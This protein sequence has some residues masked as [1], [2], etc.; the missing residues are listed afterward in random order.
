MPEPLDATLRR[1]KEERDEADRR[2]NDALTALDRAVRPPPELPAA[3][4]AYDEHQ[5]TPLNEA[6]NIIPEPPAGG[7]L[8]GRL[9][10]LIWRTVGPFLQRQLTF[11]SR[12]VDH[13]NRNVAAHREARHSVDA[14]V[15]AMREQLAHQ[16]DNHSR[17]LFFLQQI[18]P[19][20][21][22]KD[23]DSAGGALVLNASLSALA[24]SMAKRW[25]SMIAREQR[26]Q[27]R[28]AALSA[29]HEDLRAA[30]GVAQQAALTTKR[31][32]ERIAAGATAPVAAPAAGEPSVSGEVFSSRLDAYKYVAFEDQFRGSRDAIRSRLESYLPFFEGRSNV[33]DV[34]CGRGE[35]LDLLQSRGIAAQGIEDRKSTR[36]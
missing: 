8:A 9:T 3:P 22:T 34:G 10:G 11:N 2:Y 13:L 5:I 15:A 31:E 28:T 17:L 12:L 16:A 14:L 1:L 24:E 35:F 26:Y 29:A 25:E 32:L 18:T 7:G 36:L 4:A 23:R 19:Y 20:V 30:I 21:D 33:L 6:W 27:A